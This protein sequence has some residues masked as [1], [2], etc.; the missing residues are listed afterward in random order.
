M[1]RKR[2]EYRKDSQTIARTDQVFIIFLYL[3]RFIKLDKVFPTLPSFLAQVYSWLLSPL[4][5]ST[6][7]WGIGVVIT[8]KR[9][10]SAAPAPVWGSSHRYQPFMNCSKVGPF[11]GWPVTPAGPVTCASRPVPAWAPLLGLS[12]GCSLL[13]G[14]HCCGTGSPL[15]AEWMRVD[16]STMAP[17]GLREGSLLSSAL[18]HRLQGS[19]ALTPKPP[20]PSSSWCLQSCS[21]LF[22]LTPLSELPHRFFTL[23]YNSYDRG[24]TS[25][26]DVLSS[27][28]Q[29]V[30]LG[31]P[32]ASSVRH[33]CLI[34]SHLRK[35]IRFHMLQIKYNTII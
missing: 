32:G 22:P 8:P 27:E 28:Q 4:L 15:A 13:Q 26:T 25:I 12:V 6:G 31:K 20:P 10:I 19:S 5:G 29:Q 23:S 34:I 35:C 16:V 7:G 9:F 14:L 3:Q 2:H 21:S 17:H 1:W 30:H 18:L 33:N 24:T 11:Q